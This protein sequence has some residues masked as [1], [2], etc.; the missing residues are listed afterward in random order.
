M[1]LHPALAG[2]AAARGERP[3]DWALASGEEYE[4]LF[5]LPADRRD[6]LAGS[7]VRVIG[8][9]R[10]GSGVLLDGQPLPARGWN[11]LRPHG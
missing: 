9:V 3:L 7:D 6:A 8:E 11:H 2:F 10:P 1:P 4:L 5:T